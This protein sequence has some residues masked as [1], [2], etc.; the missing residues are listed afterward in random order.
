MATPP[1][2]APATFVTPKSPIAVPTKPLL[3]PTV[4]IISTPTALAG[5]N[6]AKG[7]FEPVAETMGKSLTRGFGDA[8]GDRSTLLL[9]A[10]GF[11]L[12]PDDGCKCHAVGMRVVA[13]DDPS[14]LTL[15]GDKKVS[16]YYH[17]G[18]SPVAD[19]LSDADPHRAGGFEASGLKLTGEKPL[20]TF[21]GVF[22]QLIAEWRGDPGR[23]EF[24]QSSEVTRLMLS[25]NGVRVDV[26]DFMGYAEGDWKQN[27]LAPGSQRANQRLAHGVPIGTDQTSIAD[28]PGL[29]LPEPDPDPRVR[30]KRLGNWDH[31]ELHMKF[32]TCFVSHK[33][34]PVCQW[35]RCCADWTFKVHIDVQPDGSFV[36]E[37]GYPRV[38]RGMF[39]A[40]E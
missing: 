3:L 20:W 32:Q 21:F 30:L 26:G 29:A 7:C 15:E 34:R 40:C 37:A 35:T 2:H 27:E 17:K 36:P 1:Q 11:R 22:V 5:Y 10:P 4:P 12:I 16:D 13:G 18:E 33:P 19:A 28:M 25:S 31:L 14:S 38:E 8:L 24:T 9:E 6:A 23:C 39:N